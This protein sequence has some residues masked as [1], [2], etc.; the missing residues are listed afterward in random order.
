MKSVLDRFNAKVNK[1]AQG[2]CWLWTAFIAPSGY[3]HLRIGERNA[4][5][6][7]VAYELFI[8]PIPPGMQIDHRCG[9]RICV[10]PDHLRVATHAE[11]MRN[12]KTPKDNTSGFKGVSWNKRKKKWRAGI[13]ANGKTV[14]LGDYSSPEAAHTAYCEAAKRYHGEFANPGSTPI[15]TYQP[16]ALAS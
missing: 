12:Q 10:N 7:R 15:T 5:A 8:G 4:L 16:A 1:D 13:R 6:H 2:G 9:C 11:N 3:G 14:N